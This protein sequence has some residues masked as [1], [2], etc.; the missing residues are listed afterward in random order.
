[1]AGT[2]RSHL[3]NVASESCHE[4]ALSGTRE[5]SESVEINFS[6]L[7]CDPHQAMLLQ[8]QQVLLSLFSCW[9][10]QRSAFKETLRCLI[11]L[12]GSAESC[13]G[14]PANSACVRS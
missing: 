1:M 10:M 4:R 14:K 2:E 13:S 11:F 8:S 6:L 9:C 7:Q 5:R 12:D 3:A